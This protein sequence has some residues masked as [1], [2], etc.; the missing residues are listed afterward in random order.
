MFKV[1][2]FC[3]C[4]K[5]SESLEETDIIGFF[6]TFFAF[7]NIKNLFFLHDLIICFNI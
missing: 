1:K 6:Q 4:Y 5:K 7:C 3:E 2:G